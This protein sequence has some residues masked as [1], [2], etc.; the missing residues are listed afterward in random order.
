MDAIATISPGHAGILIWAV[1]GLIGLFE[2]LVASRVLGRRRV[3]FID[4]VIGIVSAI[5]AGILSTNF[6]GDTPV[7][8]FL[9][10]VMAAIFASALVL[11]IFGI[12]L[13]K[14]EERFNR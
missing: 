4:V 14:N 12:L 8:L 5:L 2:G 9:V 1:W 13:Y 6:I 7:Q 10:S 11:W 3:V